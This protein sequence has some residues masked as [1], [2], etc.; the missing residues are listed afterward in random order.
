MIRLGKSVL[1]ASRLGYTYNSYGLVN[2]IFGYSKQASLISCR[3]YS[4]R[5]SE[6]APKLRYLFYMFLI[7]S[8][9]MYFV[10]NS[11][12]KRKV[13]KSF[14]EKEFEE[15]E[16]RTGLKRRSK[17]IPPS[18]A[19]K[20]VFYAV[21]YVHNDELIKA[22]AQR[23]SNDGSNVKIID[24][25]K[26]I[27][28]EMEDT[29]APYSILLQD[30]K[31]SGRPF[32]RGLITAIIKNDIKAYLNTRNGT[33]DTSFILKNYPQNTNEAIKFENEIADIR[34]C[35]VFHYDV[36]SELKKNKGKEAEKL[37]N[38]VINYYD[39]VD[40]VK[41]ITTK[42]DELDDKLQDFAMEFI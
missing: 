32:P 22:M 17:L 7:S 24:P 33:F 25:E 40:K 19:N 15:Y 30:L 39:T 13:K 29:T 41:T 1:R 11:V 28:K 27:D 20:Y 26:L 38:N 36:V 35:V 3:K 14:T 6:N 2:P 42:H 23:L 8:G 18:D 21:P 10:A 16:E 37:V 9:A 31:S 4:S 12:E 34:K 5:S